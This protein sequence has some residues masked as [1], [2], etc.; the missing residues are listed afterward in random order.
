MDINISVSRWETF[1]RGIVEGLVAGLP[2][3]VLENIKCLR[4]FIDNNSGLLYAPNLD[5]MASIIKR[6]CID[7]N[8]YRNQSANALKLKDV[9]SIKNQEKLLLQIL[10]T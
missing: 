8:Y 5:S 3:V 4:H 10:L 6:L 7:T 1:G 2:T 9:F